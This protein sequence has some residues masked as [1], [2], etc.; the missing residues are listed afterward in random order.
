S[1][2]GSSENVESASDAAGD[3]PV[4]ITLGVGYSTEENLWLL[5]VAPELL[6][7]YGEEYTLELQQFRANTD[8]LNAYQAG[9]LHGG[10]IGQGAAIMSVAQGVDMSIVFNIAKEHPEEGFNSTFMAT[11]DSGLESA[12]DLQGKTIGIPD[13]KSPTDMWARA[14]LREAGLDPD[15]DVEYAVLPAPAVE[16]AV[17]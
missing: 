10:T 6:T 5:D 15:N 17:R 11:I 4:E 1:A 13:F 2:C 3:N 16:E 14:A 9:Q 8:R 12:A 7:N